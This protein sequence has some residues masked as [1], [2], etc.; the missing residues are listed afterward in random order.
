VGIGVAVVD[1][2]ARGG[3]GLDEG[4][5]KIIGK[6]GKGGEVAGRDWEDG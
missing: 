4:K 5:G 3:G 1:N 2:G 6:D